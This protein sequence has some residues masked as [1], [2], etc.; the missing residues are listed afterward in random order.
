MVRPRPGTLPDFPG[1]FLQ[2][3]DPLNEGMSIAYGVD[4]GLPGLLQDPFSRDRESTRSTYIRAVRV[5]ESP[6]VPGLRGSL[7]GTCTCNNGHRAE[8]P[9]KSRKVPG[10]VPVADP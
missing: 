6:E 8:G 5:D 3:P 9:Q 1:A 4:A 10:I 7:N 2:S